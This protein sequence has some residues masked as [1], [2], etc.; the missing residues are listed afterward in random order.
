M[1]FHSTTSTCHWFDTVLVARKTALGASK[2]ESS[3]RAYSNKKLIAAMVA[4][5]VPE[6]VLYAIKSHQKIFCK[7]HYITNGSK[8]LVLPILDVAVTAK[9]LTNE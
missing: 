3:A 1:A 4:P 7:H 5:A 2:N 8:W 9:R 6:Y